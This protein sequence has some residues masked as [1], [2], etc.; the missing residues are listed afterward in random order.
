MHNDY[1]SIK[2]L[3]Q[4]L[5][6]EEREFDNL[7]STEVDN[8]KVLAEEQPNFVTT[9][10]QSWLDFYYEMDFEDPFTIIP[11]QAN[12]FAISISSDNPA[13]IYQTELIAVPNPASDQVTFHFSL[14]K[15]MKKGVILV[16][17]I[18][19]QLVHQIELMPNSNQIDWTTNLI[20]YGVY[21]YSLEIDGKIETTKR[22]I[23][24]K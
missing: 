13:N 24:L 23:V 6:S 11:S 2:S 5:I 1:L 21:F 20:P 18:N 15:E 17:D 9:K 19:G 8:L 4:I 14:P 16:R 7:H 3:Q 22:L 12:E 10:A